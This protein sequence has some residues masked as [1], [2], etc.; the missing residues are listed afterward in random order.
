MSR[1]SPYPISR[2]QI[3]EILQSEGIT[4][5]G[6][7]ELE[8]PFSIELYEA[9]LKEERHGEMAYLERHLPFKRNPTLLVPHAKSAIVMAID[10]IPHPEP[11]ETLPKGLKI[12]AYAQGRD[13]HSFIREKLQKVIEQLMA[14]TDG[15]HVFTAFTDSSPVLERDLAARAGLGW[16]GKNTCLISRKEGSFF[17]I[18]EIYTSLEFAPLAEVKIHDHCGTCTR[19]VDACPTSALDRDRKSLDARKC[20]SYLTIESQE[21]APEG[22]RSKIGDWFF[23]CDICQ[24]VCPWNVK[25]HGRERLHQSSQTSEIPQT[26][27]DDLRVILN[28]SNREIERRFHSTP[29]ARAGGF[30]LKR[31]AITV[32]ANLCL[33]ALVPE[34]EKYSEHEKLGELA[35]WALQEFIKTK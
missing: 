26:L 17:F 1:A 27:E 18:A 2:D 32:A 13:Y 5:F 8:T 35:R 29:L 31:N 9:W 19:C 30:G 10:Y 25:A 20:I 34:I 14:M 6:V 22:L 23:G 21:L 15:N 4:R 24:S 11:L 16:I 33:H 7:V 3:G 28:S 12:A